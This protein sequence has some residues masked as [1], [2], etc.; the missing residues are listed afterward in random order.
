MAV[1]SV[2]ARL[3][4]LTKLVVLLVGM[5]LGLTACDSALAELSDHELQDR[6][7]DCRNTSN[8]GQSPGF[9]I[10]CDNYK[11]ECMRRREQGKFLC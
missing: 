2:L 4:S 3:S 5:N 7:Y 11:R 10:S 8:E 6:M 1:L 9:A